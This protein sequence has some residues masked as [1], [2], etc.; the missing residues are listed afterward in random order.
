MKCKVPGC[1]IKPHSCVGTTVNTVAGLPERELG[2][3]RKTLGHT[4]VDDIHDT[5]DC[6][7]SV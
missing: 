1:S 5:T 7:A 2:L 6:A 3:V 4:I